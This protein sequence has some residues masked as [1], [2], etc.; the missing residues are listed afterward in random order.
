MELP[1]TAPDLV[2]ECRPESSPAAGAGLRAEVF[3]PLA[4]MFSRLIAG[5]LEERGPAL[6][7]SLA[8]TVLAGFGAAQIPVGDTPESY[9]DPDDP[10]LDLRDRFVKVFGHERLTVVTV[11]VPEGAYSPAG[12]ALLDKLTKGLAGIGDVSGKT[13][14]N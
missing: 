8:L 5:L 13:R 4:A 9:I 10:R 14:R 2:P 12:L 11:E 6:V 7:L 3:D 1:A